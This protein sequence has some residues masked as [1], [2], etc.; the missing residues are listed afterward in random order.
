ELEDEVLGVRRSS[1]K[2]PFR[3]AKMVR[4]GHPVGEVA[5]RSRYQL[6]LRRWA[7][8]AGF[9]AASTT[10]PSASPVFFGASR[11]WTASATT[12]RR[13]RRSPSRLVHSLRWRR[14]TAARCPPLVR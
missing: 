11:N 4:G 1:W 7:P 9:S 3:R 14:P 2:A 13:E 5:A 12:W 8:T 10:A 6:A